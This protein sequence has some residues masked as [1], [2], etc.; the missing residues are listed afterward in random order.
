MEPELYEREYLRNHVRG[1][2]QTDLRIAF[3]MTL[4][5]IVLV[6]LLG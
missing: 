2:T 3:I 6:N 4:A 1:I 5:G